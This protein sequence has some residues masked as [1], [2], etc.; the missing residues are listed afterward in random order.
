MLSNIVEKLKYVYAI[1]IQKILSL[2]PI[3]NNKIFSMNHYGKGYGDNGKYVCD[4]VLQ[5]DSNVEIIWPIKGK[6]E[7]GKAPANVKEVKYYS[8]LFF[9]HLVTAKVWISNVRMPSYF[10]KRKGQYYIQLWHGLIAMKR[11]EADAG[12]A[13]PESYIRGAK[14]D[15]KMADLFISNGKH[16]TKTIR[17][18][19][20]YN[21]KVL[22]CGSPRLDHLVGGCNTK[23]REYLKEKL[24]ICE[25]RVL[26]YAP[27]FRSNMST[28]NYNID[29]KMLKQRLTDRFKEDWHICIRLHP[30]VVGEGAN[31][32]DIEGIS[33]LSLY[34]DLYELLS[35]VDILITDY[36]SL[37]FEAAFIGIQVILFATDVEK[38]ICDRNFYFSF[39]EI[40][41]PIARNNKE[42]GHI[43]DTWDMEK[44]KEDVEEFKERIGIEEKGIAS[45]QLAQI[46]YNEITK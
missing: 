40:P 16:W 8:F 10:R 30:N 33:D 41:F 35:I 42:L 29:Y 45:K 18:A 43:I 5:L 1:T 13:L 38:Y 28:E 15:S 34:S 46:I 36:S 11:I 39:D 32:T 31:I 14:H 3:K 23:K 24:G 20:W 2:C 26:L 19:F 9:Y 27:T 12:A 17:R 4:E 44:Q 21:G 7:L 37:M 22:E 25:K 6:N